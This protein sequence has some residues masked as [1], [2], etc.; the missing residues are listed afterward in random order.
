[1]TPSYTVFQGCSRPSKIAALHKWPLWAQ[2]ARK[3]HNLVTAVEVMPSTNE[4]ASV[5]MVR[6][7]DWEDDQGGGF[8]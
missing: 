6:H 1:M 4:Q 7:F 3:Q 5:R 8:W 2:A